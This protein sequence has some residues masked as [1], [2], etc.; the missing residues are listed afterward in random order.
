MIKPSDLYDKTK[1]LVDEHL[2]DKLIAKYLSI[3]YAKMSNT[4]MELPKLLYDKI[5]IL[6]MSQVSTFNKEDLDDF[7]KVINDDYVKAGKPFD[8]QKYGGVTNPL[9]L[10]PGWNI[11]QSWHLLGTEKIESKDIAHRFYFGI[12][13]DKVYE[14]SHLLY[15][16]FK[17]KGIPFY[18]KTDSN[19]HIQRTDNLV[20]YTSTPLLEGTLEILEE[21]QKERP[22]LLQNCCEPSILVGRYSDK[23]GYATEDKES[24]T[25]YTDLVCNTFL[26]AI[27]KSLVEYTNGNYNPQMKILFQ[28]KIEECKKNNKDVSL[29]RV[30]NRIL[31]DILIRNDATFK[32]KFFLRFKNELEQKGLDVNNICF[33]NRVK[34]DIEQQYGVSDKIVLPNGTVM[35]QEE[36]LKRNNVMGFIPLT[37]KVTLGNGQVMTGEE[38]IQGV[39]KRA[40]QFNTFQELFTAYGTKV[41][42]TVDYKAERERTTAVDYDKQYEERVAQISQ[43]LLREEMERQMFTPGATREELEK[44]RKLIETQMNGTDVYDETIDFTLGNSEGNSSGIKR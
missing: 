34:Q 43:E 3:P 26:T 11:F 36:Y 41:D 23:I 17:T 2:L 18:F 37:A 7:I 39:L 12:S 13:N 4:F 14:L 42:P 31:F 28:Q 29:E 9:A 44:A 21:L 27:E 20:L 19:E 1:L 32:Q 30:K 38:F 5:N 35:T 24:K 22:D 8:P 6:D 16:K 25:S 40:G 10:M 15:D 33:N